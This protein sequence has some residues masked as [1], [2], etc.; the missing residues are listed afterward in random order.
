[1]HKYMNGERTL[2]CAFF[3][4]FLINDFKYAP[5]GISYSIN[6]LTMMMML[7]MIW[8]S[9]QEFLNE[10]TKWKELSANN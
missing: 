6:V 7:M 9:I 3:S 2:L 5:E 8:I 4:A 1:M 10:S